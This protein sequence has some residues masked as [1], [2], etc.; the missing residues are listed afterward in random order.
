[1]RDGDVAK[2][3]ALDIPKDTFEDLNMP[4]TARPVDKSTPEL[5]AP[6]CSTSKIL[7]ASEPLTSPWEIVRQLQ[8]H[9]CDSWEETDFAWQE[10]NLKRSPNPGLH[11]VGL[12]MV[13]F[14]LSEADIDKIKMASA[15]H[16]PND[17]SLSVGVDM[18]QHNSV[19][20]VPAGA[21]ET[22][23]ADWKLFSDP[24]LARFVTA[25]GTKGAFRIVK[26][27]LILYGC[28]ATGG[29][30][31]M[32]EPPLSIGTLEIALPSKHSP[33]TTTFSCGGRLYPLSNYRDS[34]Y[35]CSGLA[36][37]SGVSLTSTA[38]TSGHRLVLRYSLQ[39][40]AP[41]PGPQPKVLSMPSLEQ[42]TVALTKLLRHWGQQID[43][44]PFE[45]LAHVFETRLDNHRRTTSVFDFQGTGSDMFMLECLQI[46]C[47]NT[48]FYI[49]L[50]KMTMTTMENV[51]V[52]EDEDIPWY[53]RYGCEDVD[54]STV[55]INATL[56]A[57]PDGIAFYENI[58]EDLV[59]E[60][61]LNI[62][63]IDDVEPDET[64]DYGDMIKKTYQRK[65]A[66][67]MPRTFKTQFYFDNQTPEIIKSF[68]DEFIAGSGT[69]QSSPVSQ[70]DIRRLCADFAIKASWDIVL[71]SGDH[72]LYARI[73]EALTVLQ[74]S[75]LIEMALPLAFLS[76][77]TYDA[78]VA[79]VDAKGRDWL[80]DCLE[81]NFQSI[82]SFKTRLKAIERVA[83][84]LSN[85][86][87]FHRQ[88]LFALSLFKFSSYA[89]GEQVAKLASS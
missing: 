26:S 87:W 88:L 25:M 32:A 8:K 37:L 52:S 54:E 4:Q 73:F 11:L 21:W 72:A 58:T 28:G 7:P 41:A 57:D 78:L 22:Q 51:E 36:W 89:D 81:S 30:T 66:I 84:Y 59:D 35:Y 70:D 15:L 1:M 34:E 61:I 74:D 50:A 71:Y 62:G 46:V 33:L 80:L 38:L 63:C 18:L 39:R 44:F 40:S 14:P 17:T 23:N 9:S 77:Q 76:Q 10:R 82:K 31:K 29:L 27:S 48:G 6:L 16:N 65:I 49:C 24:I 69:N 47:R 3:I 42:Q 83:S 75:Q 68:L 12:G 86:E 45:Y 53:H 79:V 64:E 43:T 19:W 60:Q 5:Q 55:E 13:G 67:F 56:F 2:P 20:E 85:L